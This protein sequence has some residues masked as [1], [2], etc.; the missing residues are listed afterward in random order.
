MLGRSLALPLLL[1]VIGGVPGCANLG[2]IDDGT[3]VAFGPNNDG[4]LIAGARLPLQGEGYHVPATWAQRGN[5][6]GSDELVTA[7]VRVGRQVKNHT[8][9][10]LGVADLSPPGGGK[11]RW[12]G[13][14]QN[15]LDVDLLFFMRDF[16]G[17]SVPSDSMPH[18]DEDGL[19]TGNAAAAA[20][21][22]QFDTA[23]NWAVVRALLG[24]STIAVQHIFVSDPLRQSMLAYAR[25]S[26]EPFALIEHAAAVMK[27]P[28]D[29]APHDDHFHVRIFCPESDRALGCRDR[30]PARWYKKTLKY[31]LTRPSPVA[32]E[33]DDASLGRRIS[34]PMRSLI[35][36]PMPFA[37]RP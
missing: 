3:A 34:G 20:G 7:I 6:Y 37:W 9:R 17:R 4:V 30:A 26:G 10:S 32:V 15:G 27:Q 8:G 24:E 33:G 23:A 14:H 22:R 11:S 2:L 19:E 28:G 18:F 12:H 35:A 5:L 16:Q 1:A 21:R 25:L 13:S 31:G 36:A 29:S